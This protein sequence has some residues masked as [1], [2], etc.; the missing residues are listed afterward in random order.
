MLSIRR[1]NSVWYYCRGQV[2]VGKKVRIIKE[3]ATGCRERGAAEAYK[4]KLEYEIQQELLHGAAGRAAQLTVADA[5]TDYLER[6][7]GHH[8]NDVWRIGEINDV[9]GVRHPD[10][11]GKG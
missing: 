8:P 2:R 10:A 6:P 5:L 1:K 4:T 7:E 3:H 9:M 11:E